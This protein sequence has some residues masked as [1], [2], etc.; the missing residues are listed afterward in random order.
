MAAGKTVALAYACEI[1][2]AIDDGDSLREYIAMAVHFSAAFASGLIFPYANLMP[3][4]TT[5]VG[6]ETQ[7]A[8]E[9]DLAALVAPHERKLLRA[10]AKKRVDGLA[11]PPAGEPG[12][13]GDDRP[14]ATQPEQANEASAPS[15]AP[16]SITSKHTAELVAAYIKRGGL[17]QEQFATKADTTTRT[18]F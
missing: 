13:E 9:A 11:A 2:V 15:A 16:R 14:R 5:G 12:I 3:C 4:P 8:F 1:A 17:T 6:D 18:D 10:A 7:R